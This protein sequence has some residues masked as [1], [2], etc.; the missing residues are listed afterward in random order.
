MSLESFSKWLALLSSPREA[1]VSE[2]D[3]I[4]K[5]TYANRPFQDIRMKL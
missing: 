4:E 3:G 2:V 5:N 1:N